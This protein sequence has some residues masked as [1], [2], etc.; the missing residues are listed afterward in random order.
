MVVT[1]VD[2]I[3]WVIMVGVIKL[4]LFETKEKKEAYY[5]LSISFK[6]IEKTSECFFNLKLD[7][8]AGL[9]CQSIQV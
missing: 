8:V 7:G 5:Y 6:S 2:V 3:I 9:K 1:S 4:I